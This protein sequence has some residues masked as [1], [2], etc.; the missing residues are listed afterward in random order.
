MKEALLKKYSA[1]QCALFL[2]EEAMYSFEIANP[3]LESMVTYNSVAINI[4]LSDGWFFDV[5]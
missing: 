1:Q 2:L 4:I 3:S 5:V